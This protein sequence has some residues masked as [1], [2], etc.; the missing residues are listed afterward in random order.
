MARITFYIH[1]ADLPSFT[2][3]LAKKAY[4]SGERV[5]IWLTDE[6]ELKQYDQM[7]W[8]FE[9]SSFLPH[10][11]WSLSEPQPAKDKG[12]LL[13][14]GTNMPL[15]E[16]ETVVLN[17]T[18]IYWC[19][20]RQQPQRVLELASHTEADLAKARNRFRVYREAGFSV[21]HYDCSGRNQ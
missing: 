10:S 21:E 18:D 8:S 12:I 1:V 19:N 17:L 7:L 13:A 14:A 15:V 5:L 16:A 6:T 9:A 11:I 2:C 4:T 20:M 3:Q